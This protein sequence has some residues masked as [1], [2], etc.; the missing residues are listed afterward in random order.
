MTD[1]PSNGANESDLRQL[2]DAFTRGDYRQVRQLLP[3]CQRS[4]EK[5]AQL[6][7]VETALRFDPMLIIVG[8][9]LAVIWVIITIL[10]LP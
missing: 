7:A 6:D 3:N 4:D 9:T 10:S 2:E 5:S 1:I 8:T